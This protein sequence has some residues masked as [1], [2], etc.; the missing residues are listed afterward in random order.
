MSASSTFGRRVRTIDCRRWRTILCVPGSRRSAPAALAALAAK[1]ATGK[2][3]PIVF[4]SGEDPV[5][6]GLV[7]SYN[8]PGGNVTGIAALIEVLGAKRLALLREVVPTGTFI[9]ALLNPAQPAFETQLNDVQDAARALGQQ[10]EVLRASTEREIDAAF[11]TA[12]QVRAEP[13]SS[14]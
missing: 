12:T 1:T 11:A 4:T 13:C 5:K 10:I 2:G 14:A 8:R 6:I 9:A 3:I 7:A